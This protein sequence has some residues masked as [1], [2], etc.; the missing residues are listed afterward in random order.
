MYSCLTVFVFIYEFT[1]IL[2][3]SETLR[4]PIGDPH[5][6]SETH[7][8]PHNAS[9]ETDMPDQ[10][11]IGD[12]DMLHWRQT[13]F[14]RDPLET[15]M[16]DWRPIGD[17]DMLHRRPTGISVYDGSLMGHVGFRWVSDGECRF[18]WVSNWAC[19]FQMGPQ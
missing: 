11:P 13:C 1:K 17:L 15:D 6:W 18:R 10:R 9:S 12:L 16:P 7:R 2:L 19:R 14:I 8:R 5:A 3:L 4:R